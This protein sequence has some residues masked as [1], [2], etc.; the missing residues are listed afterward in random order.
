[1]Y[2]MDM[3]SQARVED[4]VCEE[5]NVSK[6]EFEKACTTVDCEPE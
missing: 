3:T 5:Q 4:G 6:P 2:C 1:M